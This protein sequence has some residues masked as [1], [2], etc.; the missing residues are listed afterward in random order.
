MTDMIDGSAREQQ[1]DQAV[2]SVLGSK[3]WPCI[4]HQWGWV[5]DEGVC[6]VWQSW[7]LEKAPDIRA[8]F[9]RI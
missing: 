8:E 9:A 3:P 5:E 1:I 2:L 7:A 4:H 6:S